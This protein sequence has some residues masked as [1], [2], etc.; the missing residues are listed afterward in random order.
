MMNNRFFAAA[1]CFFALTAALALA[2]EEGD[3][4][5]HPG[6][7]LVPLDLRQVRSAARLAAAST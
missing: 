6:E 2:A 7:M 5:P 3:L 4:P 1:S